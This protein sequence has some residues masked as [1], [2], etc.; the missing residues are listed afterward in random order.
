MTVSAASTRWRDVL[1]IEREVA[2]G[3][4]IAIEREHGDAF[5]DGVVSRDDV[6]ER[7][8]HVACVGAAQSRGPDGVSL[9]FGLQVE[10]AAGRV[11]QRQR[12]R[13]VGGLAQDAFLAGHERRDHIDDLRQATDPDAVGLAQ[14][15]IQQSADQ[16]RVLEVVDFLEQ[17]G[18]E[19]AVAIGVIAAVGA[20]PDVPLV[21]GQPQSLRRTLETLHVIADGSDLADVPLHVEIHREVTLA[22]AA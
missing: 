7:D 19:L 11:F 14:E 21:E 22:L 12:V 6:D 2:L 1:E 15:R 13:E 20:V 8:F 18:C 3:G 4:Q 10:D 17:P 5:A 9:A 16:Q